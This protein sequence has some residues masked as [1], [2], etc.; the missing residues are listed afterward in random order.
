MGLDEPPEV[1]EE[2][3]LPLE[4]RVHGR[5]VLAVTSR[6]TLAAGSVDGD[7]AAARRSRSF[8]AI[9]AVKVSVISS[10]NSSTSRIT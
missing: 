7:G 4:E 8:S 6:G 10:R 1:L 3:L 9:S 2:R 5:P